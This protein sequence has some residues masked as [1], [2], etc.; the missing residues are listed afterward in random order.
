M[1]LIA[2]IDG[3]SRGNPGPSAAAFVITDKAG[4]IMAEQSRFLGEGTNNEA[5]YHALIE[6]LTWL[7]E[8]KDLRKTARDA[9]YVRCDSQLIVCQVTGQWKVKEPR[10]KELLAQVHELKKRQPFRLYI[11]HVTRERNKEADKL[12]NKAIDKQ[13]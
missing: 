11:R 4:N 13:L 3:G 8:H 5:E 6:L 1:N 12:V 7:G 10:L 2:H 9:V